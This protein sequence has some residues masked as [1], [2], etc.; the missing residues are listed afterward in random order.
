MTT[1]TFRPPPKRYKIGDLAQVT[2]L[3][4][5]TIHNY[6]RWGLISESGWTDG[7]HR[8]YDEN[9]FDR[10]SRILNLRSSYRIDEIRELLE[11]A[12][13]DDSPRAA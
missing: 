4:R 8:L 2:G 10:L 12:A 7:G 13:Q 6:T 3:T 11:Q 1:F 5:Q 9:V